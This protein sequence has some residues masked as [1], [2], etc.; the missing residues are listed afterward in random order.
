GTPGGGKRETTA[1]PCAGPTVKK[2]VP[3]RSP[4]QV[5][6]RG[7]HPRSG[8][9]APFAG[10]AW[11]GGRPPRPEG[12][13]GLETAPCSRDRSPRPPAWGPPRQPPCHTDHTGI[14][15]RASPH[16]HGRKRCHHPPSS[17]S[18]SRP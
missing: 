10:K 12:S 16:L 6:V 13:P 3:L 8:L 11:V 18:P 7:S 1:A 15:S 17:Y 9:R 4:G 5:P 14:G 2:R